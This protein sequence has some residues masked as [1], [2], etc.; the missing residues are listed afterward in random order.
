MKK[1]LSIHLGRQLFIIEEDA[2]DRLQQYLQRLESSLKGEEGVGDIIEDI[3][4]RFAELLMSYLGETRKVVTIEDVEKGVGSLG[5]PEEISEDTPK[6]EPQ[7]KRS[8]WY[9]SKQRKFYRDTENGMLAG[10][11]SGTAAYI[12]TTLHHF[13]DC[14]S[15]CL[16][17]I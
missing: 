11:A 12:G 17:S 1:T 6:E 9:D 4:M 15:Q 7:A 8:Q 10:V 14:C 5:E 2:Y 16:Y 13:M 3:E